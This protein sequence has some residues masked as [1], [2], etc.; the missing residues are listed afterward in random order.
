MDGFSRTIR[1]LLFNPNRIIQKSFMEEIVF[2]TKKEMG[3]YWS[4]MGD[5]PSL[6]P[7]MGE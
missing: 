2:E 3:P 1:N 5:G 7:L 4:D 6:V